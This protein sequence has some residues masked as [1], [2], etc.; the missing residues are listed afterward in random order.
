M[1]TH[2]ERAKGNQT[3]LERRQASN[4]SKEY[5]LEVG[6]KS[7]RLGLDNNVLVGLLSLHIILRATVGIVKFALRG[8]IHLFFFFRMGTI[9]LASGEPVE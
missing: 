4:N 6:D 2:M 3:L 8:G 9:R 5:C 7:F 1:E